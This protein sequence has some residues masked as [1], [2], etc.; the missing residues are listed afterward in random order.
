MIPN[1]NMSFT[2]TWWAALWTRACCSS[3]LPA[4][5][6]VVVI[7]GAAAGG[8]P[9]GAAV[10]LGLLQELVQTEGILLKLDGPLS[11]LPMVCA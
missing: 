8:R 4:L 6:L 7:F 10:L 2:L 3:L 5:L 1:V 9:L 11:P